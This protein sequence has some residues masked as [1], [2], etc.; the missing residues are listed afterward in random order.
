M[1]ELQLQKQ[2]QKEQMLARLVTMK[3]LLKVFKSLFSRSDTE[4]PASDEDLW[5]QAIR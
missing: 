1:N 5:W 4:V 3:T 2:A